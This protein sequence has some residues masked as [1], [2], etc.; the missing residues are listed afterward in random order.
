MPPKKEKKNGKKKK[1][2]SKPA[3]HQDLELAAAIANSQLMNVK[4]EVSEKSRNEFKENCRK[5][6]AENEKLHDTLYQAERDT[7]EV[8]TY[9][10]KEDLIKDEQ[11]AQLSQ[12]IRDVK[13]ET[14]LE[15][16]EMTKNFTSRISSL[17][18]Q[19]VEKSTEVRLIQREL[20]MVKEF[21]RKRL[22][23]QSELEDI[24]ENLF[25]TNKDHK[26]S[27]QRMEQKFFDEKLRL[28]K[29]AN[30]K[31]SELAE[32]AHSEAINK[33]DQ[34]TRNIY[35]ENLQL[36]KELNF[37]LTENVE[38]QKRVEAIKEERDKIKKENETNEFAVKEKIIENRKN[39]QE[40]K[41]LRSKVQQLEQA[42][43]NMIFDF[44]E[45]RRKMQEHTKIEVAA[46]H[47][48]I[49]RLQQ[50]LMVKDREANRVKILAKNI[51]DERTDL[52]AFFH[53]ALQQVRDEI[54]LSRAKYITAAKDAYQQ[55]MVAAY[56]GKAEFPK[57]RTFK[58]TQYST[59]SVF[60]DLEAASNTSK[61][62]VNTDICELTWEQKE[63]V[64]RLLFAKI[65]K[66]KM[67]KV[68]NPQKL[69][70]PSQIMPE[71]EKIAVKI[72][73]NENQEEVSNT[74]ITQQSQMTN[75]NCALPAI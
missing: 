29:E 71:S 49:E 70:L 28:E 51:I 26:Q 48:E 47:D 45:E 56:S 31:L 5:V 7:I 60:D 15:K 12:L 4:L 8:I 62:K 37:H 73:E 35:K 41:A 19:L 74:F 68:E 59:N 34:S 18:Q 21:R 30:E 67:S 1:K 57:I 65:N 6:A 40:I 9:L 55:K 24:R 53:A 54:N 13:K 69:P 3:K 64:L 52:E 38:V 20:K 44:Q 16:E 75:S 14:S 39:K 33:L 36:I 2:E 23:M 32:R 25:Q 27:L 17:E 66:V 11:I 61:L 46:S 63:K 22:Q 42:I 43:S 72:L 50:L 58:K 10:K